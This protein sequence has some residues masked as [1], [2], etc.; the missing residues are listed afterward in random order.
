MVASENKKKYDKE[1]KKKNTVQR[2]LQLNKNTDKE[3]IKWLDNHR[4]FATYIKKLVNDDMKKSK[5][6]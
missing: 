3:L 6:K 5:E 2:V 4:P 1:Y